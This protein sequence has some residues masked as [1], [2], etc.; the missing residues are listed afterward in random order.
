MHFAYSPHK[1]GLVRPSSKYS[2]IKSARWVN[3][4][5]CNAA[6]TATVRTALSH[7]TAEAACK[8]LCYPSHIVQCLRSLTGYCHSAERKSIHSW[9][10]VSQPNQPSQSHT[11]PAR[12]WKRLYYS[13]C[14]AM[15]F[16]G[17]FLWVLIHHTGTMENML[18]ICCP[19]FRRCAA[20]IPHFRFTLCVR[21][22]CG[23][24][25]LQFLANTY[26]IVPMVLI[27]SAVR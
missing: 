8:T 4:W 2:S 5:L 3:V 27:A 17:R 19:V 9:V 12:R 13:M 22:L 14:G 16:L 26:C 7:S 18:H 15:L 10:R 1:S 24:E 11:A 21:E 6:H 25:S 23:N 20:V